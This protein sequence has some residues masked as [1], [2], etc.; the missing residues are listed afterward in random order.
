MTNLR[1]CK[2]APYFTS[3]QSVRVSVI[4][5]IVC[6][7]SVFE[8]K[9]CSAREAERIHPRSGPCQDLSALEVTRLLKIHPTLHAVSLQ[10]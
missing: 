7:I 9:G 5:S 10:M 1:G 4:A 6:D 8:V 2:P 3:S